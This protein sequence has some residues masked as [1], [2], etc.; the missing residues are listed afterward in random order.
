MITRD[1]HRLIKKQPRVWSAPVAVQDLSGSCYR[2]I[3]ALQEG[4][5]SVTA[6]GGFADERLESYIADHEVR[7]FL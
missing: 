4:K 3:G 1:W 5:S 6:N 2:S 7:L